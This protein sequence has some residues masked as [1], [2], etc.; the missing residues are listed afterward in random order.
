MGVVYL[1]RVERHTPGLR[2]GDRVA[3]KIFHP[4]AGAPGPLLERFL[5]EAEAGRRVDH[6]NVVRAYEAGRCV[7]GG[8]PVHYILM[9]YLEG[10]DLQG[11]LR[12]L[13]RFPEHL[14][15]RVGRDIARGL[16]AIHAAGI[17]H[18]DLKPENVLVTPEHVVKIADLGIARVGG[19]RTRISMAGEFIGTCLYGAPEQFEGGADGVGPRTDL[20]GLGWVLYQGA[21]GVHPFAGLELPAVIHSQIRVPP[22]PLRELAPGVS[23]F[24]AA[25]V[26]SLLEKDPAR[27][28]G[29][30]G[31]VEEALVAGED[32]AWWAAHRTAAGP[33]APP[34][35][36][37][38]PLSHA[39]EFA[40]REAEAARLA[41]LFAEAS[42]GRG[43]AI[44]IAGPL[45]S[46][47]TRLVFETAGRLERAG[48]PIR[49]LRGAHPPLRGSSPGA[50]L[51]SALPPA[52]GAPT[53]PVERVL[54]LSGEEPIL[55]LLED[56]HHAPE[57][58]RRLF[59][60]LAA[61]AA[62][63][64]ILLVGTVVPGG[65]APA[66]IERLPLPPLDPGES[67]AVVSDLLRTPETATLF[68]PY[69]AVLSGG[70]PLYL[71]EAVRELRARGSLAHGP[72]RALAVLP[73]DLQGILRDRL[74]ALDGP[75]REILDLAACQG[76]EFE[77][78]V[79]AG[80]LGLDSI[81]VLRR[82]AGIEETHL[83]VRRAGDRWRF[84]HESVHELALAAIPAPLQ[85]EYEG[86]LREAARPRA[87][88]P[89]G[90]RVLAKTLVG[91]GAA[92][93]DRVLVVDD[94]PALRDIL[95]RLV[96]E[97]GCRAVPAENGLAAVA[98]LR[99]DPPD[100]V[101]TD[102]TMPGLG[103]REVLARMKG[104][105]RLRD[106]PAIVV[107]GNDD[108]GEAVA[109]IEA[110]AEDYVLKP[111]NAVLLRAR[112]QSCLERRRLRLQERE[113]ARRLEEYALEL[114]EALRRAEAGVGR[115]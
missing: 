59:L 26:H 34:P 63:R 67:E 18:R 73:Q 39:A 25:L 101:L 36:R 115:P 109:C 20:Y 71:V 61:A 97:M 50:A 37:G 6:P 49:F 92:P 7:A 89:P 38:A 60:E 113:M 11:L 45:G 15:R 47:R 21:C 13:G 94:D 86:A 72:E 44:L 35:R 19:D 16:S 23:P 106:I 62:T 100:L 9:E 52:T 93:G 56:L 103:G 74:A 1:A 30:A 14:C 85:R 28:P 114:E 70:N 29:S 51:L 96:E 99:R 46:G 83:L 24:F 33:A 91:G 88:V 10:T 102:L 48:V 82:L 8:F 90:P 65:P 40:G 12:E 80:A 107:T 32:S 31:E 22:P 78:T 111:Y 112:I 79:V 3:V 108:V 98:H 66:G 84:E 104:D 43:S 110:G 42:R 17:V 57:E 69:L 58:G 64:P 105:P 81:S 68:A 54:A 4:P 87:A 5:R 95:C 27:R 75:E 55:L 77:P 53:N 2:L 76:F 41:A